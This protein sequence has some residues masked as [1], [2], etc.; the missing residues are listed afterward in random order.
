MDQSV[1][2]DAGIDAIV[3]GFVAVLDTLLPLP[4]GCMGAF[5]ETDLSATAASP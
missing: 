5:A 1:G 3:N 4:F 2:T